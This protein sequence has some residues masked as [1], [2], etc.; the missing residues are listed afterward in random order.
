MR[1]EDTLTYD[2]VAA[3]PLPKWLTDQKAGLNT[4]QPP[5]II[6]KND[7]SLHISVAVTGIF[8]LLVV[9]LLTIYIFR[10]H[11]NPL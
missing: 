11:K 2:S 4:T 6:I 10:K 9:A 3:R 7:Y 5:E 1:Q 8:V